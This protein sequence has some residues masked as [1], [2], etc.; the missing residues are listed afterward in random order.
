MT[1]IKHKRF[2]G[3]NDSEWIDSEDQSP[4]YLAESVN[5]SPFRKVG[6]LQQSPGHSFKTINETNQTYANLPKPADFVPIRVETFSVDR[7]SKEITLLVYY[8]SQT[9]ATKFYINP[10]WNPPVGYEN[11]YPAKT[12]NSWVYEWQ[13]LT[14][15]Y[16]YTIN[17]TSSNTFQVSETP[18]AVNGYFNGWFAYCSNINYDSLVAYQF[19]TGYN[20][21]TKTFTCKTN[22]DAL[23]INTSQVKLVR[24]PVVLLHSGI[25]PTPN[26][27]YRG[28]D[29]TF[30]AVP[31]QF[32]VSLNEV[33]IPCGKEQRPL[34]LSMLKEKKYLSGT[35]STN[36]D[37]FW[38]DFQQI[39]Q[40]LYKSQ[41]SSFGTLSS[42][43]SEIRFKAVPN[44]WD[45]SAASP[46]ITIK[47]IGTE[48]KQIAFFTQGFV[49]F[50]EAIAH[51]YY[52]LID[53]GGGRPRFAFKWI[54]NVLYM[55]FNDDLSNGAF[56]TD[57]QHLYDALTFFFPFPIIWTITATGTLTSAYITAPSTTYAYLF[58]IGN[59]TTGL[60]ANGN[61]TAFNPY[62][63][64][65]FTVPS[66]TSPYTNVKAT[67]FILSL[68]YDS[69]NEIVIANGRLKTEPADTSNYA[70]ASQIRFSMWFSR[71]L[72]HIKIYTTEATNVSNGNEGVVFSSSNYP[73]FVWK[74]ESLINETP[75]NR[76]FEIEDFAKS[77]NAELSLQTYSTNSAIGKNSFGITNHYWYVK[78]GKT[79]S[80]FAIE[81]KGKGLKFIVSANRFLDQDTT[82]NYT[83]ITK[84]GGVNGRYF[85]C[86]V[87]N[88]IEKDVFDNDDYI[89][90]SNYAAGISSYDIFLRTK[91]AIVSAGDKD[92]CKDVIYNRG[93]LMVIKETNVYYVDVRTGNELEYRIVDT[94]NGRGIDSYDKTCSTPYGIVICSSD[95]VWLIT[96]EQAVPILTGQNGRL[97]LYYDKFVNKDFKVTYY[98]NKNELLIFSTDLIARE[99]NIVHIFVYS[100][101]FQAWTTYEYENSTNP[102]DLTI[103]YNKD[104]I[105]LNYG[106][107]TNYNIIKFNESSANFIK[108]DGTTIP[109]KWKLKTHSYPYSDYEQDIQLQWIQSVHDY[110]NSADRSIKIK[111]TTDNDVDILTD[112][113]TLENTTSSVKKN[114]LKKILINPTLC[115][116]LTI[117]M[118]NID[119][120][121]TTQE[122]TKFALH[123]LMLWITAQSEKKITN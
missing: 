34:I 85:I 55:T 24:F 35:N 87:K 47:Y 6:S 83:R 82:I 7:D 75:L 96:N 69:R 122:F 110:A 86:N 121:G 71:R 26:I 67:Q 32:F 77:P 64:C 66:V 52:P 62:A 51:G 99:G 63:G 3:S 20:S 73:Y 42:V 15:S 38:F 92:I 18:P 37:G 22:L 118:S 5:L 123:N 28:M 43:S 108:T 100:F 89:L 115:K 117:E 21:S 49:S 16:T 61:I 45:N 107:S 120:N 14:E 2:L 13:E 113:Y 112:Y 8:N 114:S 105:M 80:G 25:I 48:E 36:W 76:M 46:Y 94:M 109:I 65:Q 44:Y 90:Y 1:P 9:K 98:H 84:V 72:S 93:Y 31:T 70:E 29:T 11:H 39:P 50:A 106:N 4:E 91:F 78:I 88:T 74:K 60:E 119:S 58:T 101:Q 116:N 30:K 27:E 68:L 56:A 41:V 23:W 57:L 103:D 59:G 95:G 12:P 111:V 53:D 19:I 54:G 17:S 104:I 79:I 102:I 97:Q 81:E 10:Y 33:R 40:V